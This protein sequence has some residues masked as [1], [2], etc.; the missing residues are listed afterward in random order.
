MPKTYSKSDTLKRIAQGLI[1]NHHPE[2]VTARIE[3]LFVD[4]GASKG[5]RE[6]YGKAQKLSGVSEFLVEADFLITVAEDRWRDLTPDQQ[7]AVVDHLLEHCTGEEDEQNGSMKWKVREPDTQEFASILNRHGAWHDGL[8]SF[9]EV[10][11]SI[12]IDSIAAEE[13]EVNLAENLVTETV[14]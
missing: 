13:G 6:L 1:P 14:N 3:Y 12:D 8:V 5:G 10:A 4:K 7:T 9:V 2:L 11:K